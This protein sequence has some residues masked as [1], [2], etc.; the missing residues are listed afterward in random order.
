MNFIIAIF[1]LIFAMPCYTGN[2]QGTSNNDK[3]DVNWYHKDMTL[4]KIPG[5]STNRAYNELLKNK[6]GTK[7]IVAILDDGLDI[8]H[9]DLSYMNELF[10]EG[11]L[12][13]VLDGPFKLS[14]V[15]EAIRYFE[16]GSF[17]GKI[18]ITM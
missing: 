9:K 13:P 7:I 12:K 2:C 16:K 11:K 17:K 14:E 5:I 18:I 15:P 1:V 3:L 4:D 6:K 8:E 10:E